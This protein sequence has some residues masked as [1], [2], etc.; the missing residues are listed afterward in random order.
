MNFCWQSDVLATVTPNYTKQML[1]DVKEE[2][3]KN[4]NMIGD[5]NTLTVSMDRSSRQK[6]NRST[7]ILNVTIE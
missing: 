3:D 2:T 4:P 7:E 5:L 1:T 6:M